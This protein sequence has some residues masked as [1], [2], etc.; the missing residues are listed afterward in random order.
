MPL[1]PFPPRKKHNTLE[2]P[3]F[4]DSGILPPVLN[5]VKIPSQSNTMTNEFL[6]TH[7]IFK[8]NL[9]SLYMTPTTYKFRFSQGRNYDHYVAYASKNLE[10][11]SFWQTKRIRFSQ[12]QFNFLKP[13]QH[14]L[15]TN[16][17]DITNA[18][19]VEKLQKS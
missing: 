8:T 1:I 15:N 5:P 17:N 6:R 13:T 11:R 3:V 4:I 12:Y 16:N 14:D 9:P 10:H 18:P 7:P 2:A 19:F